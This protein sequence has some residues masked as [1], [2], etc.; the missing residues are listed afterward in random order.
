MRP[1]AGLFDQPVLDKP[2]LV[3]KNIA[4][5]L[6]LEVCFVR[7]ADEQRHVRQDHGVFPFSVPVDP[8][9]SVRDRVARF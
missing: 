2:C 8:G 4:N 9:E 3:E 7:A 5:A 1:G 6:P